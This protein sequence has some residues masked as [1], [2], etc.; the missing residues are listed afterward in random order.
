LRLKIITIT[1]NEMKKQYFVN[2]FN[3]L[4]LLNYRYIYQ[5]LF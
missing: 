2:F 4:D 1:L 3:D 5:H